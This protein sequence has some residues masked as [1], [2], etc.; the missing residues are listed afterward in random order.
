V[1]AKVQHVGVVHIPMQHY[2][3]TLGFQ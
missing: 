1:R 2:N 3:F